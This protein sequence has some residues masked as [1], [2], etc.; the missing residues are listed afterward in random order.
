MS[1]HNS[2]TSGSAHLHIGYA[3]NLQAN[4]TETI[5][6]EKHNRRR[7][8][9]ESLAI[10]HSPFPVCNIGPSMEISDMWAA[11]VL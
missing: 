10:L 2:A 7:K 4:S 3:H 8:I 6:H 5:A 11:C 1:E 9:V